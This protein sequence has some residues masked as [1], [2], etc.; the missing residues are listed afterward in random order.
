MVV[1][2][3][4]L[5]KLLEQERERLFL[6][7][8]VVFALGI[9]V[10]FALSFEPSIWLS[11][12]VIETMIVLAYFWRYNMN[13]LWVLGWL[14]IF[15]LGFVNIQVRA[16][17]LNKIPLLQTDETLYLKGY[18]DKTGY[19]Y[20]GKQYIILDDMKNFDDEKIVGKY[21]ITPLYMKQRI[22]VGECVE[23]VANMRPLMMPNTIS[24]FWI[25]FML[26]P[27]GIPVAPATC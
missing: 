10:F 27:T 1:F 22:D 24:Q 14:A 26:F 13:K 15:V 11:L 2:W 16:Y 20:K 25:V 19:N 18:V 8:P 21:K 12:V 7:V 4:E 3:Y 6:W 9:A 17:H 5:K 23:M